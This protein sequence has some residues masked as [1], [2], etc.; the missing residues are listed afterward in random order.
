LNDVLAADPA[1]GAR[2]GYIVNL[3]KPGSEEAL[4]ADD[5]AALRSLY[6][7][8]VAPERVAEDVAFFSQPGVLTAAVNW[9]RAMSRHD[10]D[11][12][13][14]V[15]VPTTYVWGSADMAFGQAAAERTAAYT[16]GPYEFV[17]LEGAGH[18]LPDEAADTLAEA[19]T[20][21]VSGE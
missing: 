21:R 4:L 14:R 18:W 7:D 10:A 6:G 8:A 15:T 11:D 13:A 16:D 9:Y 12:L 19:I 17:L 2:F 3:R 1:Q 20:R 5:G